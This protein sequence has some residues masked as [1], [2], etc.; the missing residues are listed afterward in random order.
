M[1]LRCERF[2]RENSTMNVVFQWSKKLRLNRFVTILFVFVYRN[3][4]NQTHLKCLA[5]KSELVNMLSISFIPLPDIWV[6]ASVGYWPWPLSFSLFVFVFFPCREKRR[7]LIWNNGQERGSDVGR[8][9][10]GLQCDGR[11][12]VDPQASQGRASQA[13]ARERRRKQLFSAEAQR[14]RNPI[15]RHWTSA[16]WGGKRKQRR[17]IFSSSPSRVCLAALARSPARQAGES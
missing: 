8:I 11:L 10:V 2:A 1:V 15:T 9:T 3:T 16:D 14:R 4:T 7:A 6:R 12:L 13:N 5:W 17:L